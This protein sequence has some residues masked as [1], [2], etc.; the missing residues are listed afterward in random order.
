MRKYSYVDTLTCSFEFNVPTHE[1]MSAV[2][3]HVDR[4]HE[5]DWV[6]ERCEK[7]KK[8]EERSQWDGIECYGSLAP[9]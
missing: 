9:S 8:R 1:I 3:S 5:R 7:W 4:K 6:R 2:P